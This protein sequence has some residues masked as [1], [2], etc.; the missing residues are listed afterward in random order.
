VT[1]AVP[2]RAGGPARPAFLVAFA[3]AV[4]VATEFIAI[5]LLPA[6]SRDLE[7]SL[8]EAGHFVSVFA[9][10]SAVLG[11][12]V[13]MPAVRWQPRVVMVVAL[14]PF[15]L[16]NLAAAVLPGY[17]VVLAT[18]LLQGA[19]L[20]V[21]VSIG[22]A[23][24]A[25]LAGPGRE[26]RAVAV[27]YIGVIAG[28][29]IAMPAGTVLADAIDW[30][31]SFLLLGCLSLAAAWGVYIAFPR[32]DEGPPAMMRDQISILY[33]PIVW[34]QLLLSALLFTAM[35]TPYTYL[36]ALLESVADLSATGLAGMLAWFGLAG[37]PGNMIAGRLSDSRPTQM[38]SGIALILVMA[39]L[40]LAYAGNG[41]AILLPLLAIWGAAHAAAFLSSQI[42]VMQSAPSAPA[43]AAA[44]N[45]SAANIGIAAGA[46]AGGAIIEQ[47]S[48]A[49]TGLGGAALAVVAVVLASALRGM[50]V[51]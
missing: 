8:G 28:T 24:V 51:R 20:P 43:F 1:A 29:V 46:T 22:S 11:P 3:T 35:F 47:A 14:V 34:A 27:V 33:Q 45:I 42:R 50:G 37:I 23:A 44:L 10:G 39:W 49:A 32:M 9:L 38:T 36:A 5:G 19:A 6:M 4:V 16:G 2:T 21:L 17:G 25:D 41:L 31:I 7:I 40:A 12:L 26:G 15:A 13:T 30:R 48:V 18:R